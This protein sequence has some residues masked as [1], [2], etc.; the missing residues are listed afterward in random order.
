[1][2]ANDLVGFTSLLFG[3]VSTKPGNEKLNSFQN[4]LLLFDLLQRSL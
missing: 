1:M 2:I 4:L 3:F